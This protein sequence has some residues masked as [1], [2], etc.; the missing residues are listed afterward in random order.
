GPDGR[1]LLTRR[2]PPRRDQVPDLLDD[3]L[4]DRHAI[5]GSN[6]QVHRSSICTIVLSTIVQVRMGGRQGR[7]MAFS[8]ICTLS[9]ARTP[10]RRLVSRAG[11]LAP[12][13]RRAH[14]LSTGRQI[15]AAALCRAGNHEKAVRQLLTWPNWA[16]RVAIATLRRERVWE[17][18]SHGQVRLN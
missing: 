13:G 4:V 11:L 15:H 12:A 2:K 3:L 6:V 1:Q 7:N 17:T 5:R 8:P 9:D 14:S 10:H 18:C 16:A